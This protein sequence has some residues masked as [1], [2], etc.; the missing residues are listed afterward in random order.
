MPYTLEAPCTLL[1]IVGARECPR[2]REEVWY[3]PTSPRAFVC[4]PARRIPYSPTN[5]QPHQLSV[6]TPAE[7]SLAQRL[8]WKLAIFS[9]ST[10]Q[11]DYRTLPQ[12]TSRRT[13]GLNTVLSDKSI[14]YSAAKHTVPSDKSVRSTGRPATPM[15]R[16]GKN[17]LQIWCFC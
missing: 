6:K 12:E 4:P 14:P 17:Y 9:P 5:A 15:S 3:P 10:R 13:S 1:V 8:S 16:S 2:H 7:T 11:R